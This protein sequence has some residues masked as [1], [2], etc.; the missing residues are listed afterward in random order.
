MPFLPSAKNVTVPNLLRR[1]EEAEKKRK[2]Y[3][4]SSVSN[5]HSSLLSECKTEGNLRLFFGLKSQLN[6]LS[7][8]T[9]KSSR[10]GRRQVE[11]HFQAPGVLLLT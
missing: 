1:I 3:L 7:G 5:L 11:L 8:N 4:R 10:I 2:K 9:G 6:Q